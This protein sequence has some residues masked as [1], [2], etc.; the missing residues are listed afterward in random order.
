MPPAVSRPPAGISRALLTFVSSSCLTAYYEEPGARSKEPGAKN[1]ELGT[2][3]KEQV[4][5]SCFGL[6]TFVQ[7]RINVAL[8]PGKIT[9]PSHSVCVVVDVLRAS[10]SIVTLLEGGSS[11][12]IATAGIE[13]ARALHGRLPDHLLCGE[14]AGLPPP[15]FDY[16][17]SPAEFSRLDL[18][19]KGTILA[20]S[21]GT[22]LLAELRDAPAVLVGCLLNRTATAQA[23]VQIAGER[24]LGVTVVCSAAYGGSTFVLE[25]ALGAGAII[26]AALSADRS[27][28]ATDAA[29]FTRDAFLTARGDLPGTIA[30]CY[31]AGEL[32]AVG[33]G[34]DVTYCAQLDV[35]QIVPILERGENGALALLPYAHD[36]RNPSGDRG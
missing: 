24:A 35:S 3:N 27:L 12:V 2:G 20:T 33:L 16:G 10:S 28:E 15:G 34:D 26:D 30:S 21:N 7:M 13:E 36:A 19:G 23:A 4:G 11:R 25:D 22:R 17:N 32:T 1:W 5:L 9:G 29:R 18:H 8:L 14:R 31:H 6:F